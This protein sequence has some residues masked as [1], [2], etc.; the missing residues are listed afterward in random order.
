MNCHLSHLLLAFRPNELAADDRAALDTHLATCPTCALFAKAAAATDAAFRK[1]MLAVPVPSGLQAKLHS[2]VAALQRAARWRKAKAWGAGLAAA[3]VVGLGAWGVFESTKPPLTTAIAIGHLEDERLM[4]ERHVR[5]W[6]VSEGVPA[7]LPKEF[8]FRQHSAHGTGPLGPMK[9]PFVLFQND[10]GQCRVYIFRRDAVRTPP[11]EW[12]DV[13]GSEYNLN[14]VERD[15]YV[16]LIAVS[17]STTLD[18]FLK[19]PAPVA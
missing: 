18:A 17:T 7:D 12:K 8:D 15:G 14:A 9:V 10:R 19:A 13:F 2:S 16:Y 1:A 3:V 11:G 6:L 4:K 5:E